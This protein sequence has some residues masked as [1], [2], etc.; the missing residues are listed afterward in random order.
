MG[1]EGNIKKRRKEDTRICLR[2]AIA[3]FKNSVLKLLSN[4]AASK[5]TK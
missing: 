4:S 5:I 3:K 2:L 1:K